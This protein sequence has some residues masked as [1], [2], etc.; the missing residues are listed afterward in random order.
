MKNILFLILLT[1][2]ILISDNKCYCSS[3]NFDNDNK[4]YVKQAQTIKYSNEEAPTIKQMTHSPCYEGVDTNMEYYEKYHKF[5]KE[6]NKENN[7]ENIEDNIYVIKNTIY[8][9]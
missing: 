5:L 6:N 9:C 4:I 3:I 8:Y 1:I 7:I 2:I